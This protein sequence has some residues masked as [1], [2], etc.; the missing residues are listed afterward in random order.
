[1]NYYLFIFCTIY[2]KSQG[3]V[4][5]N[6]IIGMLT[7]VAISIGTSIII[8]ILRII[9]IKCKNERIYVISRYMYEHF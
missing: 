2:H 7:S 3:S 6:Y 4:F 8:A 5:T 1:M 9:S